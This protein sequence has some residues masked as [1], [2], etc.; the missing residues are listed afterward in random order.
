MAVVEKLTIEFAG[1]GAGKLTGQL[2]A[3]SAA[4]NRLAARQ[5]EQ[6]KKTKGN[7]KALNKNN[8]EWVN[9]FR[10]QNRALGITT[11]FGKAMSG[12][13][14]KL[15]IWAFA[16]GLVGKAFSSLFNASKEYLQLL[17]RM[18]GVIKSTGGTASKT[19]KQLIEMA[20]AMQDSL[21]VAN[22]AIMGIQSRLLTFTNITGDNFERAIELAVDMST[23]FGQDLNQATIQLGKALNDPIRGI[24]ALRR[25]GVSFNEQQK[26]SIKLFLEQGR[27]LEAQTV[28]LEELAIE[29]GGATKKQ[30][31]LAY[32]ATSLINAKNAFADTFRSWSEAAQPLAFWLGT[33]GTGM[34]FI[35]EKGKKAEDITLFDRMFEEANKMATGMGPFDKFINLF[36]FIGEAAGKPQGNPEIFVALTDQMVAFN[37]LNERI[38]EST[39]GYTDA[40]LD[41]AQT[42]RYAYTNEE[43][44]KKQ[45]NDAKEEL[46][47]G[48]ITLEQYNEKLK[49]I[50]EALLTNKSSL[51]AAKGHIKDHLTLYAK[52]GSVL[53][54]LFGKMGQMPNFFDKYLEQARDLQ[55]LGLQES[56][57]YF[58]NEQ[59]FIKASMEEIGNMFAAHYQKLFDMKMKSIKAEGSA[60]L[61]ELKQSRRYQRASATKR[62]DMEKDIEAKTNARLKRAFKRNQDLEKAGVLIDAAR[63]TMKAIKV[64]PTGWGMPWTAFIAAQAALQLATI[65]AQKPPKMAYGGLIGG[66]PHSRG[67]T[68]IEAERG[69]FVISRRGVDAIGIETL[70]RINQ[71]GGT[72]AINI[73]FNGNVLS[74][75]FIEDEA[76]PQIKEAIRRG[77][78]IGV[79]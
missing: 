47:L 17:G 38:T 41:L 45:L 65:N 19:S 72:G 14:S 79:G 68:M 67:G 30:N 21:S 12:L 55:D 11:K 49:K 36:K 54:N 73:S 69:E 53:D 44:L 15:L 64:N 63:A 13:R 61:A 50:N 60:E 42:T 18:N 78:D 24:G 74:K 40:V 16:I 33:I 2:N 22:V 20:D 76:I 51:D 43:E 34:A 62:E 52:Y 6:T 59:E 35:L 26:L 75:D 28:I 32:G 1:K 31:E 46:D 27:I 56:H 9:N 66:E 29:F 70:N 25:I 77:A 48:A 3:L 57:A 37:A 5:V 8:K 39:K 58:Q 7:T 10:N 23:V 71:G 4:M